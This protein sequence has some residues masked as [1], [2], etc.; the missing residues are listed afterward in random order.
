MQFINNWLAAL[1]ADLPI[2][3]QTLPVSADALARLNLQPGG[4]YR[5]MLVRSLDPLAQIE[6]EV[7]EMA[8]SGGVL[9]LTRSVEG[10]ERSWSAGSYAFVTVTAGTMQQVLGRIE[11]LES[12]VQ[13]L[14]AGGSIPANALAFGDRILVDDQGRILTA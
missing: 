11:Q 7:V 4:S 5:L 12:R 3:G 10:I 9:R 2:G 14:E 8:L 6:W 1:D 13:A